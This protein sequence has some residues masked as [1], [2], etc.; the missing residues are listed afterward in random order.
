MKCPKCQSNR[1]IKVGTR[2]DI[3]GGKILNSFITIF[4]IECEKCHHLFQAPVA[5]KSFISFKNDINNIDNK[6]GK[7]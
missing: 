4:T 6:E 2:I 7:N 5:N 3:K 1:E